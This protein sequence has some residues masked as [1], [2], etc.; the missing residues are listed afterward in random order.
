MK[1]K[2]ILFTIALFF[3]IAFI[4]AQ[5]KYEFMIIE[6]T[7]YKNDLS[8]SIDGKEFIKE[9]AEYINQEKSGY[10]ANPFL[11]KVK[12]YQDKGWEV[13]NLNSAINGGTTSEVHFAHLRKKIK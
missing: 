4:N 3:S 7:T 6:F 5:D 1:A 11:A 10:N 13:W 2:H 8:V 9:K 12:F